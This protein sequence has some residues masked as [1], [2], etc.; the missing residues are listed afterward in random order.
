MAIH[1]SQRRLVSRIYAMESLRDLEP[2]VDATV[3]RFVEGMRDHQGESIDMFLS[4]FAYS[5]TH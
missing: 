3:F 4:Q 2:Y 5:E 1:A